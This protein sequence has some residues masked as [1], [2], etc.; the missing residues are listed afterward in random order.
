[1]RNCRRALIAG[2]AVLG[3]TLSGG[4]ALLDEGVAGAGEEPGERIAIAFPDW[5]GG[6]ANAAVAAYVLETELGVGVDR[7][8]VDQARAW[9]GLNDGTVQAVLE[10]W[11]GL[12]EKT[13]LYVRQKRSV[14]DAGDLGIT[15]HIGWFVPKRF[16]D[17][18]P[19]VLD[20]E[21]LN[22]FA[23][24][25]NGELLQ[26]DAAYATFDAAIIEELGLDLTPVA[27]GSESALVENIT[28]ASADGTPLLTYWWQ[29]HWLNAE[30]E[31]AEIKLPRY[32]LGCQSDP[33]T[34]ACAYP[35][36]APRKYLNAAFA[37]T[38]TPAAEFLR[39]FRWTTDDQNEVARLIEAEGL[40]PMAAAERWVTE[41][42]EAVEQWLPETQD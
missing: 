18:H 8:P 21:N 16:S 22:D 19:E 2:V 28:R 26:A 25:F 38:E 33:E 41:N 4:C 5:P 35:D 6:Q 10:D 15:G 34:V 7:L 17:A 30:V 11:G 39:A 20:W 32:T 3:L 29:P 31:M 42:P 27:A 13:E 1:M 23:E 40:S 9:D 36:L 14:V 24:D 37:Q 12:P